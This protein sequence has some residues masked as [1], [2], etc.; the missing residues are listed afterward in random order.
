M[1]AGLYAMTSDVPTAKKRGKATFLAIHG[2]HG[3]TRTTSACAGDGTVSDAVLIFFSIVCSAPHGSVAGATTVRCQ[4]G[5]CVN[6]K[7]HA[8]RRVVVI[9]HEVNVRTKIFD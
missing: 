4:G 6:L 3:S 7:N 5:R 9:N 1:A 8:L 2:V